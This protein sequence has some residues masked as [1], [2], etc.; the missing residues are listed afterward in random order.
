LLGRLF[1]G[2]PEAVM[3]MLSPNLAVEGVKLVIVLG[4]ITA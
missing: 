3:H 2:L 4:D 1:A